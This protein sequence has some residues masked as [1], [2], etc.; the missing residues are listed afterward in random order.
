MRLEQLAVR[1]FGTREQRAEVERVAAAW[2]GG[3][4]TA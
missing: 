2:S 1:A 3:R 4:G